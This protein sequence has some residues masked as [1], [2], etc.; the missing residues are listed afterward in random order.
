MAYGHIGRSSLCLPARL[1][2]AAASRPAEH[3]E[4]QSLH[5]LDA[6]SIAAPPER[7]TTVRRGA[8]RHSAP[9]TKIWPTGSSGTRTSPVGAEQ[10]L[11]AGA[12][13]ARGG[14]A[15]PSTPR[16]RAAR[17]AGRRRRSRP[18]R[19]LERRRCRCCREAARGDQR[20]DARRAE[21]PVGPQVGLDDDQHQRRDEQQHPGDGS[22]AAGRCRRGPAAARSTPS[23]PGAIRPGLKNSIAIPTSPS[24][25]SR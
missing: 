25:S 11:P 16:T 23:V 9:W 14:P 4:R 7:P 8:A 13:W 18:A 21:D 20:D 2:C 12:A 15:P 10:L 6:H 3:V 19:D 24:R 22:P 17:R 1:G 5:G